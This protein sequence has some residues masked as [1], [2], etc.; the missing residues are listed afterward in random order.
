M[1]KTMSFLRSMRF[2]L[3]LMLP[4]LVCAVLGSVVPQGESESYYTSAFPRLY[5]LILGLGLDHMF[6][7]PVFL[8]LAALFGVNLTLCCFSQLQAV[9]GRAEAVLKAALAAPET[10]PLSGEEREKLEKYLRR[11][12]FR[13]RDTEQGRAYIAPSLSWHGSVITHF[14]LLLLLLG[15]AGVFGLAR[16]ADYSVLP[17][18]N[19]LPDGTVIRLEEFR[20]T[21]DEGRIEYE[22]T[23][24]ITTPSGRS[25]G[26][27]QIRV[28]HPLR[29][30][31]SKYYQQSYG[32]AG[33]LS[34][35]VKD[36]GETWPVTMTDAGMISIGGMDGIWYSAV[37]PGYV[38]GEDGTVTPI[39]Q[40]T[41]E[42]RDPVYYIRRVEGGAMVPMMIFPGDEVET[43]DAV[44]RFE[45]PTVFP[46][47]R[48]KTTPG[49]IYGLLYF[50]FA[51]LVA[52]LYLCFFRSAA[53][54]VL[55]PEG[56]A[57][58][59]KSSDTEWKQRIEMLLRSGEKEEE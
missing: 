37:Y 28:N 52:G 4:V 19:T 39:P 32:V 3:L 35:T 13:S 57:L 24:E 12:L 29:F 45:A 2:G 6:R 27:R 30:G 41:G 14:A 33:Q 15:A 43:S 21:D 58:R 5:H 16:H 49:W 1:K 9:P 34:V 48:V 11:N 38:Q 42:Y 40:T 50:S 23:L 26:L 22:S 8:V 7:T 20:S 51:L 46:G 10:E 47:I 31:S 59:G 54:A 36:T 17:G 25:S 55:R 18:E 53:V 44:Y 56:Y